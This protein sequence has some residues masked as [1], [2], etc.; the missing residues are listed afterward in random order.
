MPSPRDPKLRAGASTVQTFAKGSGRVGLHADSED[1]STESELLKRAK[2]GD[3]SSFGELSER[4]RASLMRTAHRIL[5]NEFDA[6]DVVQDSLLKAFMSLGQF[7]EQ[8]TFQTWATRITINCCLMRLRSRRMHLER[9]LGPGILDEK[10]F[11]IA[12]STPHP[13]EIAVR[14]EEERLLKATID[15]LPKKL[16]EVVELKELRE[17]KLEDVAS[18]LGTSRSAT[19][20]NLFR[21]KGILK[22][23]FEVMM[24]ANTAR[25]ARN[26]TFTPSNVCARSLA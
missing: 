26:R 18:A 2:N 10:Y 3:A 25:R 24:R 1:A 12:G 21:A 13:E 17:L 11:E 5:R 14:R 20:A 15:V 8:S 7:H 4:C 22:K 23:R 6:Q 19:K 16:R 9:C